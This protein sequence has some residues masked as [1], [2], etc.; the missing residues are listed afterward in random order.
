MASKDSIDL[1]EI[2]NG[3]FDKMDMLPDPVNRFFASK[4]R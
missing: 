2:N 1:Y 3:L 4:K